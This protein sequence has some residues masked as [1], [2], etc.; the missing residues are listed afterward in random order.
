MGEPGRGHR[1]NPRGRGRFALRGATGSGLAGSARR[2]PRRAGARHAAS[3]DASMSYPARRRRTWRA[4]ARGRARST[5]RAITTRNSPSPQAG[6]QTVA[7]ASASAR[8]SPT[9]SRMRA[10]TGAGVYTTPLAFH[11]GRVHGERW[12]SSMRSAMRSKKRDTLNSSFRQRQ[13]VLV[14]FR[15]LRRGDAHDG[16]GAVL[17]EAPARPRIEI[18]P[19]G[20]MSLTAARLQSPDTPEPAAAGSAGR[21]LSRT[22][23]ARPGRGGKRPVG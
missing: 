2:P 19:V 7:A 13:L 21:V 20:P 9:A 23:P 10:T 6:S 3:A 4:A 16:G 12:R 14:E 18:R 8:S 11:A 5:R 15:C 22:A 17:P 1:R